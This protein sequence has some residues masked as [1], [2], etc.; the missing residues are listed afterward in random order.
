[1][2]TIAIRLY[3]SF[4]DSEHQLFIKK[5]PGSVKVCVQNVSAT[6]ITV[7][8]HQFPPYYVAYHPV[9]ITLGL[10]DVVHAVRLGFWIEDTIHP[11]GCKLCHQFLR[12]I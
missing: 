6:Y 11:F 8:G 5:L 10:S 12:G 2:H 9:T 3:L 4:K 1:V 7:R